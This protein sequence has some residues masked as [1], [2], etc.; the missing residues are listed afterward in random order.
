MVNDRES[1]KEKILIIALMSIAL[2]GSCL[3]VIYSLREKK[4]IAAKKRELKVTNNDLR[5]QLDIIE[6]KNTFKKAMASFNTAQIY[7]FVAEN[8]NRHQIRIK[9]FTP[10]K[11][12]NDLLITLIGT[13]PKAIYFFEGLYQHRLGF[14][15]KIEL[16]KYNQEPKASVEILVTLS[17][18]SE[19]GKD[20]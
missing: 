8:A 4:I 15:K 11:D 17:T 13:Y 3:F 5:Q 2:I 20:K 1:K 6:Y 19:G 7:N 16:K 18:S 14:L 10:T 9:G 12:T